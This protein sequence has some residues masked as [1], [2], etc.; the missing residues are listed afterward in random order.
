MTAN[1]LTVK[2]MF[3]AY[4]NQDFDLMFGTADDAI[5][6]FL[7]QGAQDEVLKARDE[8]RAILAMKLPEG[9]LQK[10]ILGDL[11]SCYYYSSEWSSADHWLN[12]VLQL[13]D[14]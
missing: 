11:G 13:L 7:E 10:L 14:G 6:A 5:R 8:M 1:F 12:H 9:E 2:N 4:L 3:S